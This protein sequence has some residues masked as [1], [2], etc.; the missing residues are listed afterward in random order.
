M[1]G[2]RLFAVSTEPAFRVFDGGKQKLRPQERLIILM[3]G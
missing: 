3:E 1:T 2:T